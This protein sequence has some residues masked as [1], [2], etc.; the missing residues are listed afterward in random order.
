LGEKNNNEGSLHVCEK[1][2]VISNLLIDLTLL[3]V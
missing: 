2:N 3:I 1:K